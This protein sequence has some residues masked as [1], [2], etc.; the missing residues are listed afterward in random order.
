MS[1]FTIKETPFLLLAAGKGERMAAS[2]KKTPKVMIPISSRFPGSLELNILTLNR[3]HVKSIFVSLGSEIRTL[4]K[5][6]K[7]VCVNINTDLSVVNA[8]R[9]YKKGPLYSFLAAKEYLIKEELFALMPA[10]TVFH[11]KVFDVI[12]NLTFESGKCYLLYYETVSPQHS[13]VIIITD[14]SETD[15]VIEVKY[16]KDEQNP[17]KGPYKVMVPIIFINGL[18]FVFAEAGLE[19]SDFSKTKV[20]ELIILY[21]RSTKRFVA[22]PVNHAGITHVDLD[23]ADD[24]KKVSKVIE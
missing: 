5:H 18:F 4:T 17:G 24:F 23:T 3:L 13:D 21:A 16:Y 20:I 10:D 1:S 8:S 14:T 12:Q 7:S 2:G 9:V 15:N 11:P 19:A 6:L 22:I